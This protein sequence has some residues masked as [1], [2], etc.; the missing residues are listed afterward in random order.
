MGK[1]VLV[2]GGAGFIGSHLVD[3]LLG[4]GDTVRVLDNFSTGKLENLEAVRNEIELIEGDL[5]DLDT[6][7]RAV[8]GVEVI[9]HLGALGSVPRSVAD[10][11]TT[12][13]VNVNGTMNV[14]IGARE[15]GV[16]RVVYSASSSAY[17]NTPVLPKHEGMP[18]NPR[19]PYAISKHVG[20]MYLKV[21]ADLYGLESLSLRYFNI[22]GPRQDEHSQYAAVIPKMVAALM[23]GQ[24]PVINGNGEHSRDFT[25]VMNAV[26]A[27]ILAAEAKNARG[28]VMN[29]GCGA[30]YSLLDLFSHL[31]RLTDSQIQPIFGPER[32]G[33]VKASLADIS[34]AQELIGYTPLVSFE[35]GLERTVG[36]FK[37]RFPQGLS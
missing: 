28:Q 26:H 25:Y 35:R 32:P 20:E 33:D 29:I 31:Q 23:A 30:Q 11:L 12:H 14:L 1:R 22:F 4:Q 34:M 37:E 9:F 3:A 8:T 18:A 36:W 24:A 7:R 21:F 27:N 17:G 6:V 10:P 13:Q 16:R 5:C 19:S 2:T 15:Y